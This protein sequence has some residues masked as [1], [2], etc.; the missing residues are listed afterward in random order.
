MFLNPLRRTWHRSH[1]TVRAVGGHDLEEV[2]GRKVKRLRILAPLRDCRG[3]V[4][5]AQT[6]LDIQSMVKQSDVG[7]AAEDLWIGTDQTIV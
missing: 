6:S 4:E 5:G 1:S 7:E 3:A 2:L